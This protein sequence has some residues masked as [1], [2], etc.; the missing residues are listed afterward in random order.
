M[1]GCTQLESPIS[2][3]W[4]FASEFLGIWVVKISQ[5]GSPRAFLMFPF[6]APTD[7]QKSLQETKQNS[8]ILLLFRPRQLREEGMKSKE[9]L[10][11]HVHQIDLSKNLSNLS[12]WTKGYTSFLGRF[13]EQNQRAKRREQKWEYGFAGKFENVADLIQEWV[14]VYT[15]KLQIFQKPQTFQQLLPPL[16]L[17]SKSHV[18]GIFLCG[19]IW[20][21][22]TFGVSFISCL[23]YLK[24]AYTFSASSFV[25]L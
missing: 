23:H 11:K 3:S 5:S 19:P 16:P 12:Q 4:G 6:S 14:R 18:L 9:G 22:L 20:L 2:Q 1:S 15:T 8:L 17:V 21:P 7:S 24:F 10:G 25:H 13:P